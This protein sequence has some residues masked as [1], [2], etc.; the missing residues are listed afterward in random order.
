M[1][2]HPGARDVDGVDGE[3]Q[4]PSRIRFLRERGGGGLKGEV[5]GP[6]RGFG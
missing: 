6:S 1:N 4:S 2:F 3:A 5:V